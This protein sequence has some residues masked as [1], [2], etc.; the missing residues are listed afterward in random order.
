MLFGGVFALF[1]G[2]FVLFVFCCCC[3][4]HAPA[5]IFKAYHTETGNS[6]SAVRSGQWPAWFSFWFSGCWRALAKGSARAGLYCAIHYHFPDSE[7]VKTKKRC[8]NYSFERG[9]KAVSAPKGSYSRSSWKP[10]LVPPKPAHSLVRHPKR[11]LID[12]L[13]MHLARCANDQ[14]CTLLVMGDANTDLSKDDGRDLPHFKQMLTDLDLVSAAQSRWKASSL[15]S[16][17]HKGGEVHRPSKSSS[18][19]NKRPDLSGRPPW[20]GVAIGVAR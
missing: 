15:H 12:D 14:R 1:F 3:F 2:V 10:G 5:R 8:G 11:L 7:Y 6:R 17:T 20:K 19:R 18:L 9:E 13:T 16:K 4:F